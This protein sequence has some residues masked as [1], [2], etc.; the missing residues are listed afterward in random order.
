[1]E[2]D[3]EFEGRA[4]ARHEFGLVDSQPLV[5]AA[6]VRKSGLADTDNPDLFRLNE[7]YAA[8]AWKKLRQGRRRHPAGSAAAYYHDLDGWLR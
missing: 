1:L 4:R 6:E 8:R 3:A 5:E 2:F 7:V